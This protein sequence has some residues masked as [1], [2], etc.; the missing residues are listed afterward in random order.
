MVCFFPGQVEK[1]NMESL[2]V[3]KKCMESLPALL[4]TR[5]TLPYMMPSSPWC[6]SHALSWHPCFLLLFLG[7]CSADCASVHMPVGYQ[8]MPKSLFS[9]QCPVVTSLIRALP[10]FPN[11]GEIRSIWFH[12]FTYVVPVMFG[13]YT[14]CFFTSYHLQFTWT[15]W[16]YA[17]EL[18]LSCL[19]FPSAGW[20]PQISVVSCC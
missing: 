13:I 12:Y 8:C 20:V 9:S 18:H 5:P 10:P 15:F 4:F 19:R 16:L 17:I 3:E 7:L 2:N 11:A 6:I 14:A 1:K